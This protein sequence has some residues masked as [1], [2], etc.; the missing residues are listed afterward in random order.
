MRE[1]ETIADVVSDLVKSYRLNVDQRI[2]TLIKVS[3]DDELEEEE[4]EEEELEEE[5]LEENELEENDDY[6]SGYAAG[7]EDGSEHGYED[8]DD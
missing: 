8:D 6:H 5:E 1:P 4:L 7:Y 3:E 2:S